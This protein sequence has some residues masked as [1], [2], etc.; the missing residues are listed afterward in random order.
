MDVYAH[1]VGSACGGDQY[2]HTV[3]HITRNG[4]TLC[5]QKYW[6]ENWWK[7]L[8]MHPSYFVVEDRYDIHQGEE[9]FCVKCAK[10]YKK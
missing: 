8:G 9:V 2:H 10:A 6:G 3:F 5:G 1:G 7:Q 4:R